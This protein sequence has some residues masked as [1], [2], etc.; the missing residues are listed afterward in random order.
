MRKLFVSEFITADG[1]IEAPHE[2]HG[3]Y[4]NEEMGEAVGGQWANADAILLGRTTYDG[5]A[6]AWP[7]MR[8]QPGGDF[9]NGTAKYVVSRTLEKAEWEN[10]AVIDG[11]GDVAAAI[12]ELKEGPGRDIIVMGSGVLVDFL[13]AE[14]LVDEIRLLVDPVIVGKGQRLFGAGVPKTPLSLVSAEVFTTGVQH[15]VYSVG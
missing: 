12:R 6:A 5:F 14:G 10:S 9:M 2:W 1:V 11:N 8:D 13:I 4:F 3:D 7:S 15:L